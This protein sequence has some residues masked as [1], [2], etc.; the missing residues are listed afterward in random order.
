MK[1][2][3]VPTISIDMDRKCASCGE[4]GATDGGLCLKCITDK[5]AKTRLSGRHF[6]PSLEI[7][8]IAKKLIAEHHPLLQHAV[9]AYLLRT[10]DPDKKIKY[11]VKRAGKKSTMAKAI[12]V[13]EMYHSLCGYDFILLADELFWRFLSESQKKA[14]VDHELCH[15]TR[16]EDGYYTKDHDV[17]E[18]CAVLERHGLWMD[19][20]A[21][22][23][24][25]APE[26]KDLPFKPADQNSEMRVH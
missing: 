7:E 9:I 3:E 13:P 6:E 21:A 1:K 17:A 12:C 22:F 2:K 15:F 5:M 23:I 14:L 26:Q 19:D 20:L 4:G 16:D 10:L 24:A 11:P 18:F 8:H 25:A